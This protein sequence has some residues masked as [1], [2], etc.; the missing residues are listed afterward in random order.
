MRRL[1]VVLSLACAGFALAAS[2]EVRAQDFEGVLKWRLLKVNPEGLAKVAKDPTD[3]DEVFAVPLEKL[4]S[5]HGDATVTDATIYVKGSKIRAESTSRDGGGY[6]ITDLESG[7][8]QVVSGSDKKVVEVSTRDLELMETRRRTTNMLFQKQAAGVPAETR[9]RI[10]A[11][12]RPDAD[13]KPPE[14]RPLDEKATINGL[15]TEAFEVRTETMAV[16]GWVTQDRPEVADVMQQIDRS[17]ARTGQSSAGSPKGELAR[18]GLPVRVQTLSP[19]DYTVE[20]LVVIEA[21]ALP[22]EMFAVP[23]DFSHTAASEQQQKAGALKPP[24]K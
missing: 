6:V 16:R 22:A 1:V 14:V 7:Q 12:L 19:R 8:T 13:R 5:L 23:A 18:N 21:K 20:D 9:D 2:A 4:M 3:A 11:L 24:P 17:R 10:Q 15:E